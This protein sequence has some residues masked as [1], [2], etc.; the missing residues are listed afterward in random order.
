MDG[1]PIAGYC[2][3][4][5]K[6]SRVHDY[7]LVTKTMKILHPVQSIIHGFSIILERFLCRLRQF[8]KLN[9]FVEPV[10]VATLVSHS[11]TIIRRTSTLVQLIIYTGRIR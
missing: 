2:N 8:M 10:Q 6:H 9:Y 5:K 1:V 3:Q 7:N 4:P 11:N